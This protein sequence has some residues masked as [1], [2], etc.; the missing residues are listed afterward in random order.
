[1]FLKQQISIS[2]WILKDPE[3]LKTG[4]MMLK[5]QLCIT[6]KFHFKI[7]SNGK[8]LFYIVIIFQNITDFIVFLR[9]SIRLIS[10]IYKKKKTAP[11][12][13]MEGYRISISLIIFNLTSN[14]YWF[15]LKDCIFILC[16]FIY[17]FVCLFLL[18][19]NSSL[20]HWTVID[21]Q[22]ETILHSL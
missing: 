16:S 9:V 17:L 13:W 3:T 20:A 8:Q 4:V 15:D 11:N 14:K 7:Y 18:L 21:I 12:L 5:I 1:M 6:N 19:M 10:K 2:E 22:P